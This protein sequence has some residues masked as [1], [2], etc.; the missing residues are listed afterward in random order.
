MYDFSELTA[1]LFTIL[2]FVYLGYIISQTSMDNKED[3][4]NY[5][6]YNELGYFDRHLVDDLIIEYQSLKEQIK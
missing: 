1:R 5:D 3:L 4:T 2:F 6:Y